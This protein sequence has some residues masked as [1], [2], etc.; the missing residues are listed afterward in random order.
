[1]NETPEM[2]EQGEKR[3]LMI[4]ASKV[5]IVEYSKGELL[6]LKAD[7]SSRKF[8]F[9]PCILDSNNMIKSYSST[10]N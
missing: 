10:V 3:D 6:R 7:V 2:Q 8:N 1:M 5:K 4:E 9:I